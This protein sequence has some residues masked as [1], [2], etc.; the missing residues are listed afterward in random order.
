[1]E[2][3][4]QKKISVNF[5]DT[6]D[7]RARIDKKL[8][9]LNYQVIRSVLNEYEYRL[10]ICQEVGGGHFEFNFLRYRIGILYLYLRKFT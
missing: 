10:A 1:M 4:K 3:L 9:N 5:D 7:L 2:R 6:D 8:G